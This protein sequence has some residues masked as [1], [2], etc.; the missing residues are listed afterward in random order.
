MATMIDIREVLLASIR[1]D[2]AGEF[3]MDMLVLDG[4]TKR[5]HVL[6]QA[7]HAVDACLARGVTVG[8]VLCAVE[9]LLAESGASGVTPSE[10]TDDRD[11]YDDVPV[12]QIIPDIPRA[13]VRVD[14]GG[15]ETRP[16]DRR[17]DP[18]HPHAQPGRD[19]RRHGRGGAPL[20][21]PR[22]RPAAGDAR[23]GDHAGRACGHLPGR[24]RREAAGAAMS[25]VRFP[26]SPGGRMI[27][28][29]GCALL[30]PR[31]PGKTVESVSPSGGAAGQAPPTPGASHRGGE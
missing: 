5:R 2:L 1:A 9:G 28:V 15:L 10:P 6:L 24:D 17:R 31:T 3:E 4:D 22:P 26:S 16:R 27:G 29:F 8:D 21:R 25:P 7:E 11:D 18:E 12:E 23:R 13:V 20:G 19:G 14:L 30:D